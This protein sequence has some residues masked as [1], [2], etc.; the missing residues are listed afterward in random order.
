[1]NLKFSKDKEMGKNC[2]F[3][4]IG[5]GKTSTR[6]TLRELKKL[7]IS[8]WPLDLPSQSAQPIWP[9]PALVGQIGCADYLVTSKSI[10]G[11]IFFLPPL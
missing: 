3:G 9:N 5:N 10:V 7:Y 2:T 11:Y 6:A 1:M 4:S 8:Q